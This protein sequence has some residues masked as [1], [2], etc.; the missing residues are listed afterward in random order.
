M[1]NKARVLSLGILSLLPA[2]GLDLQSVAKACVPQA[3]YRLLRAIVRTESSGNP[4]AISINRP[5]RSATER[6]ING[7]LFLSVQPRSHGQAA[8]WAKMLLAD[9]YT[10]SIG[11][12]QVST[13]SGYS[14]EELLDHCRNLQIGWK[15]FC[16]KYQ[17]ARK[18]FSGQDAVRVAISLYN[19]GSYLA[20][21][22]NGYVSR[23]VSNL[24]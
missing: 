1:T 14:I 19:S 8:R 9:H 4:W 16:Q 2:L 7:R 22:N 23:V 11:L 3:D 21:F 18:R 15:I 5:E 13:E 10:L 6:G 24:R 20:G 17:E 12:M